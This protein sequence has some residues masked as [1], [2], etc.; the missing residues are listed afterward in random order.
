MVSG[1]K[2]AA[3]A[4]VLG[5]VS[6]GP[7]HAQHPVGSDFQILEDSAFS[8][9]IALAP[10]GE[11]LVV[12]S[13]FL[14]SLP[15]DDAGIGAQLFNA[16]GQAVGAPFLV[17]SYTPGEQRYPVVDV[18]GDGRFVVVW[19]E[20]GDVVRG[21]RIDAGG[22]LL[23][24]E[25][26]VNSMTTAQSSYADVAV[27][28]NG[29]FLVTW[30]DYNVLG[31]SDSTILARRFLSTGAPL[32]DQF[33]VNS[34]TAY[35][36]LQS[37]I[38]MERGTGD[39]VVV[40]NSSE[41]GIF[42]DIRVKRYDSSGTAVG[43]EQFANV[44]TTGPQRS[45]DVAVD[46]SGQFTVT[47]EGDG[48]GDGQ[49]D[50][51]GVYLRQHAADGTPLADDSNATA[52]TSVVQEKLHIASALNGQTFATWQ[53]DPVGLTDFS[54]YGIMGLMIDPL[55]GPLSEFQ[56]NTYTTE[57]QINPRVA[58]DQR[59]RFVVIWEGQ[60]GIR[61]RRF[62]TALR[63]PVAGTI[64]DT[65][66]G[67]RSQGSW[68]DLQVYVPPGTTELD[69]LT[70][71]LPTNPPHDVDLYVRRAGRPTV[72]EFDCFSNLAGSASDSCTIM[73]PAPGYWWVG[74]VN[75]DVG[76]INFSA[77]MSTTADSGLIFAD[78]FESGDASSW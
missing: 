66:V 77:S 49:T 10:S 22:Q 41:P 34:V 57:S 13:T 39:F 32:G 7:A 27:A 24:S 19:Q 26:V 76:T 17:N 1:K 4:C 75:W 72:S 9:D 47:W 28:D 43:A 71:K 42:S 59:G 67:L 74:V 33:R 6:I 55:G 48:P 54:E 3:A 68:S 62:D 37:S 58:W 45:P 8:P 20:F 31:D 14:S 63:L 70:F 18:D 40:W 64:D 15:G 69:V 35:D 5:L 29:D 23:G 38:G 21:R 53:S 50:Y 16:D 56:V 11:F 61:G 60:G 25:F 36:Q 12:W 44:F 78:G 73:D 2:M 65:V 52:F 46:A 51:A 30:T